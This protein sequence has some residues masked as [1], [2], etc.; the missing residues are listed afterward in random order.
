MFIWGS[1]YVIWLVALSGARGIRLLDDRDF[2][3]LNT[4]SCVKHVSLSNDQEIRFN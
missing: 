3:W 1:G 2:I 4:Q